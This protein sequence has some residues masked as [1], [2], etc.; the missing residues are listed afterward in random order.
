M[1]QIL[2]VVETI[3]E[4]DLFTYIG[5]KNSEMPLNLI[6][7]KKP[8]WLNI[9]D[10]VFCKFQE[11]RVSVSKECS[12]K[13]SIE[14]SIPATIRQVRKNDLLCELTL[15]SEIGEVVSLITSKSYASLDLQEGLSV[16]ILLKGIDIS[17][18]PNMDSMMNK[19]FVTFN[20][21]TKDAN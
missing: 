21:R 9:G 15:D 12:D 1:N 16:N 7:S 4:S 13:V 10:E 8:S 19:D 3:Q 14:N 2:A 5:V 6:K 18:E 17:L 11:A 20:P